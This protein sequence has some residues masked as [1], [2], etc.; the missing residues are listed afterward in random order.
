MTDSEN[1][2]QRSCQVASKDLQVKIVSPFSVIDA[3]GRSH[4]F[5]ALFPQFAGA[6]GTLICL[7]D[8][9]VSKH[10]IAQELGYYCS[11]LHPDSYACYDRELWIESFHDWGWFGAECR[12]PS[13]F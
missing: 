9:W 3:L 8:D 13:W 6:R 11:G 1:L 12:Q 5:V 10:G 7:A 4:D 2:I